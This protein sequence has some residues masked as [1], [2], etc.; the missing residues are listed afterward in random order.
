M[1]RFLDGVVQW[2]TSV[3]LMYTGAMIIYLFFCQVFGNREVS[4]AMLWT[5][6]L[7]CVLGSLC[8]GL[9]YSNWVFKRLRYTLRS[10]LFCALYLP[11]LA[12]LGWKAQWFPVE[13]AGSWAIFVGMFFLVFLLMTIGFDVYFR[14]TGRK[15]DG[16]LGQYRKQKEEK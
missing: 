14:L 8:Q 1:K 15:Y 2:K 4:T 12:V 13:Q 16:L 9:C 11:V 5:M 6:L 3:C 10:L 7:A